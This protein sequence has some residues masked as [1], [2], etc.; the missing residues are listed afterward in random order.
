MSKVLTLTEKVNLMKVYKAQEDEAK[1]A[2]NE[3]RDEVL[4]EL[5]SQGLTK[6]ETEE[7]ELIIQYVTKFTY[8]DEPKMV[9]ILRSKG[10]NN[11]VKESVNTTPM[12]KLLKATDNGLSEEEKVLVE[13][14]RPYTV[15][16]LSPTVKIK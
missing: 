14:I 16:S 2:Y 8:K 5:E 15:E 1:K 4:R 6:Y 3:L 12:N 9:E 10:F 13:E 7:A 11:L